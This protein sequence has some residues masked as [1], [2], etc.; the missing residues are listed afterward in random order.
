MDTLRSNKLWWAGRKTGFLVIKGLITPL[1]TK[2]HNLRNFIGIHKQALK[3]LISAGDFA[4][5]FLDI[6]Y[7]FQY[8]KI[9]NVR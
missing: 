5:E 9:I 3:L 2:M 1:D 4:E 6:L 8:F 7:L